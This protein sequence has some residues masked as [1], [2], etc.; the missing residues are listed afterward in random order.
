MKNKLLII[1]ASLFFF[2]TSFANASEVAVLDIDKI[3]KE[4]KAMKYIQNRLSKQ[5]DKYQQLVTD[6]QEKLEKEQKKLEGKKSVLSKEK[7][8]EEVT[9]FEGKVDELKE[10]VDRKQNNLKKA[11]LDAMSVVNEAVK[12]IVAQIAKEKDI[13]IIIQANEALYFRDDMDIS[14]EVLTKLNKKITKVTIK[15]D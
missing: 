1:T 7:F 4:S 5:Q 15:F 14:E 9:I 12:E 2:T 3:V 8:Q 6:K 10:F 11:S 13:D